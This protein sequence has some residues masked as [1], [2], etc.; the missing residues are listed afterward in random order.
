MPLG[1]CVHKYCCKST[2]P[3]TNNAGIGNKYSGYN[4]SFQQ[5]IIHISDKDQRQPVWADSSNMSS[6]FFHS[7]SQVD[8]INAN[9]LLHNHHYFSLL[10][11]RTNVVLHEFNTHMV[12][13]TSTLMRFFYSW[14]KSNLN[15]SCLS[16]C[17]FSVYL[18][19]YVVFIFLIWLLFNLIRMLPLGDLFTLKFNWESL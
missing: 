15:Q 2:G 6:L 3:N 11:D 18:Y 9:D 19:L 12:D 8:C 17:N 10:G 16:V 13:N 1:F 4:G 5:Q 7:F 14:L